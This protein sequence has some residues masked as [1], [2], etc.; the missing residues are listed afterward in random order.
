MS[1]TTPVQPSHYTTAEFHIRPTY[2]TLNNLEQYTLPHHTL[3]VLEFFGGMAAGLEALLRAGHHMHIYVWA[4]TNPNAHAATLH[5]LNH[6]HKAYPEQLRLTTLQHWD[7]LIPPDAPLVTPTTLLNSSRHG[8][9]II[10][11]GIPDY[12]PDTSATPSYIH[13]HEQVLQQIIH[14]TQFLYHEQPK[15]VGYIFL[16]TP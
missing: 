14:L 3:T 2:P 1:D 10:I 15:G 9:D 4:D 5:R 6:L 16:P 8:I 13:P 12:P 11:A 7:T